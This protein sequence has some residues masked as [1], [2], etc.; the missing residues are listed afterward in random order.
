MLKATITFCLIVLSTC[1]SCKNNK[2]KEEQLSNKLSV[3][4]NMV[5]CDRIIVRLHRKKLDSITT[6]SYLP[7][8]FDECLAQ[9]D[10]IVNDSLKLWVQCLPDGYFGNIVHQSFG[11]YLRNHWN[12]LGESDLSKSL[13]R[14]GIIHPDDMSA[15]I[16]DSYQR[17]LKNEDIQ[18]NEQIKRY[19]DYWRETG[20]AVDSFLQENEKTTNFN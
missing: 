6:V 16:L 17:K 19:Q 8:N 15:I 7:K 14:L 3:Q 13:N 5:E 10:T 20:F 1:I 12:L 9:L 4:E 18:L 11:M 2:K